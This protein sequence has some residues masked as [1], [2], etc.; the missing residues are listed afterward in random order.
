MAHPFSSGWVGLLWVFIVVQSLSCLWLF[1]TPRTAARQVPLSFTISQS[2]HKFTSIESVTLS[3]HLILCRPLLPLPSIFPSI[4]VFSNES[5]FR[6]RWPKYWGFLINLEFS[7]LKCLSRPWFGGVLL[8][9]QPILG[10]CF[11]N[12]VP[13]RVGPSAYRLQAAYMPSLC[14]TQMTR[15]FHFLFSLWALAHHNHSD[16]LALW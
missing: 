13:L 3:N 11:H 8:S 16:Q 15:D 4:R 12:L 9:L 2:W 6:I 10:L 1:A 14:W 5:G 7:P